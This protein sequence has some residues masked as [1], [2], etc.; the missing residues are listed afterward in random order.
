MDIPDQEA[1][2]QDNVLK[3]LSAQGLINILEKELDQAISEIN[4]NTKK[5]EIIMKTIEQLKKT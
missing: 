4:F 3:K 5:S 2:Y 1:T